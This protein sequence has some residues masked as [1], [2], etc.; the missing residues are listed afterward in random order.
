MWRDIKYFLAYILPASAFWG[1]YRGGWHSF[2]TLL[3]AF[4]AIPL[5]EALLPRSAGNIPPAEEAPRSKRR[6]FDWL[7]YLNIPLLWGLILYLAHTVQAG[8]H[9]WWEVL[10][11]TLSTG[12]IAGTS[13][14]NVGHE[15]GHRQD[16]AEQAMAKLLLLPALYMH[17][18]IEHN[19]GHH[20]HVGTDADPASARRGES[21][22][23]FWWRSV[24]EGYLDAWRLEKQKLRRE[25]KN[26][27]SRQNEMIRF[28]VYQ[29]LYMVGMAIVFGK[30]VV[31][32]LLGV[33]VVAF[34]LL[35]T[36][37][38]IEHY[39]LRRQLLPNQRYEPVS[40]KHSWNS[41]HEIG[42]IMLYELTRHSD[43]HYKAS[44]KYQILRHC[45]ES[46]QLPMGYPAAVLLALAPPLWFRIMD[47]KL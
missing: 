45:E 31:P 2:L 10:G 8:A 20:K 28:Q 5:L 16:K 18:F 30:A 37:N 47:K 34:L 44:R 14:I 40:P 38:Y 35:E 4:A 15:L 26:F 11:M 1:I 21:L 23:A 24:R 25:D 12:L 13:G 6:L 36:I 7:L 43:H 22:Y 29:A 27:W 33:A 46:P 19:K 32:Y 39:G 3:I 41:D 17:F 9:A 42:R